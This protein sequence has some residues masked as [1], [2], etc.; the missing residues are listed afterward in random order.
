MTRRWWLLLAL[1]ALCWGGG[2]V[3]TTSGR[4]Q[5]VDRTYEKY[6]ELANYSLQLAPVGRREM[7]SGIANEL[8]FR[9]TNQGVNQ[10]RIADWYAV[11]TDNIILYWQNWRP[12]TNDPNPGAWQEIRPDT[13]VGDNRFPLDLK[14]GVSADVTMP[15]PFLDDIVVTPGHERRF[16]IQAKLNLQSVR[17]ESKIFAI[18]LL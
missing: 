1:P 3:R 11:D 15:L 18:V 13:R 10:I 7:I 6:P 14:P 17:A 2:C 4:T 16:W 12:G 9:L 5:V 8:T